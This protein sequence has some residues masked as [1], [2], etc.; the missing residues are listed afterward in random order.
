MHE[1]VDAEQCHALA[2]NGNLNL[3]AAGQAAGKGARGF[4][5]EVHVEAILAV[6]GEHVDHGHAAARA[7]RRALHVIHLRR[8]FRHRVGVGGGARGR[9][10]DGQP[11][12]IT[13][14][15]QIRAQQRRGQRLHVGDV[16]EIVA[17]GVWRE[18]RRRIDVELQQIGNRQAILRPIQ[19]LKRTTTGIRMRDG[20]GVEL[21]LERGHERIERVRARTRRTYRRHHAGTQF[22]DD[23]LRHVGF[24]V[25]GA[26][27]E[28]RQRQIAAAHRRIVALLTVL[29]DH[30]VEL[31]RRHPFHG[32]RLERADAARRGAGYHRMTHSA[33]RCR[34][35]GR[36]R[37]AMAGKG[38]G[39]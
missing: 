12:Q 7:E 9:V 15:P 19:S 10:A 8:H 2:I 32:G 39:E 38:D 26:H 33:R 1:A 20:A 21:T 11:A 28:V 17:L 5:E 18:I 24:R 16:V 37:I 27:I 13:R 6:G 31:F 30:P 23:L 35:I 22:R 4:V 3:F 36:P 25:R 29:L 14:R 34:G